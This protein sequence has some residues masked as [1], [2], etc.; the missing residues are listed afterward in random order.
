M[1]SEPTAIPTSYNVY[2][3]IGN[4]GFDNGVNVRDSYYDIEL[5]PG[6]VYN[7]KITACNRGGE[8]FPTEILSASN[9]MVQNKPF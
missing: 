2:T 9:V 1:V 8:S 7:F 3:S 4:S 6:M 5:E